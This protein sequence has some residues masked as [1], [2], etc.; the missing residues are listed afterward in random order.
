MADVVQRTDVGMIQAGDCAGFPLKARQ[1]VGVRRSR[2]GENFNR[3]R[4][5]EAC[6][7]R[8]VDLAHSTD[9]DQVLDLI[10]AQSCAGFQLLHD[11]ETVTLGNIMAVDT[12]AGS[13]TWL[14]SLASRGAPDAPGDVVL[15]EV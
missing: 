14:P 3:D 4:P 8:F 12:V 11:G 13:R 7:A 10:R 15:H 6:V 5:A 9:A 1:G 2:G